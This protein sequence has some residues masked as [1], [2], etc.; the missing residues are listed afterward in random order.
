MMIMKI[1]SSVIV[2]I[3]TITLASIY[4]RIW[5]SIGRVD[6]PE[7]GDKM[8]NKRIRLKL[9]EYELT[10]YDLAKLLEVSEMT[11]YR[12]LRD[13]LPEDEQDRIVSLI[14]KAGDKHED[15]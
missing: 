3:N 14:E 15:R 10:Q 12:K 13:E 8:K 4:L 6:S 1:S 7:K 11:V 5:R 2:Y 9:A